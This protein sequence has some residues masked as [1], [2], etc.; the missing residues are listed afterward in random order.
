MS[1]EPQANPF[2]CQFCE[3][4]LPSFSRRKRR[5]PVYPG[6]MDTDRSQLEAALRSYFSRSTSSRG[7]RNSTAI[8]E[9]SVAEESWENAAGHHL[10]AWMKAHKK[11]RRVTASKS[12]RKGSRPGGPTP[13]LHPWPLR[14]ITK[15][16]NSSDKLS[17]S[18]CIATTARA[19]PTKS[20][21]E[22]WLCI[23]C[24][25]I[26]VRKKVSGSASDKKLA[27]KCALTCRT[28]G[29]EWTSS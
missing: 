25:A 22:S 1:S 4:A 13:P 23:H 24:A 12:R 21:D 16:W 17:S 27:S 14:K 29:S 11:K 6:C 10:A 9:T 2:L 28:A 19:L 8:D 18:G 3:S 26:H 15:P 5:S 7:A 20:R